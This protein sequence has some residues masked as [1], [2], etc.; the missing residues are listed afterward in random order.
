[1]FIGLV[2]II[3][4]SFEFLSSLVCAFLHE[5]GH[6]VTMLY[7]GKKISKINIGLSNIDIIENGFP[8]SGIKTDI[9]ILLSGS[10]SN[11]MVSFVVYIINLFFENY[12]FN[13]FIYQ[14]IVIGIFNLLPI[15]S[16]DGGQIFY[17]L[18]SRVT[19]TRKAEL[20]CN[21]ISFLILIPIFILSFLI[22]FYSKY[23]FSL[24]FITFYLISFL[25]FK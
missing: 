4:P 12:Y 17:I 9:I 15:S 6:I 7:N 14:N 1:M 13:I 23:N 19:D 18:L 10:L 24:L 20:I 8:C 22:L 21:I 2:L 11:F 3:T 25:N 5:F 16:L